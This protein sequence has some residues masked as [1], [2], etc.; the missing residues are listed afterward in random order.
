M[1]NFIDLVMHNRSYRR[2]IQRESI[3]P[4]QMKAIATHL[5]YVPSGVNRQA[6]KAAICCDAQKNAQIFPLL[7]W[8]GLLKDWDGPEEGQRP[9]GYIVLLCDTTAAPAEGR[10][11]DVGIA[12]QTLAL[13][14]VEE[15][16]GVCMIASFSKPKL[17]ELLQ[18]PEH[19]VPML[20]IALG[21]PDECVKI[22]DMRPGQST[23]YYRDSQD[24]HIVPKRL[25][26][27]LIVEL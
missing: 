12:A 10:G 9:A 13:A 20:V 26:E 4:A 2:F 3:P 15:G 16:L 14:A 22:E 23:A 6:L 17:S 8:A 18:L 19:L 1:D 7:A 5:R 21:K 27:D 25:V 11:M 24:N